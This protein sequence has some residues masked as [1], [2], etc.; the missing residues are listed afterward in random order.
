M[1]SCFRLATVLCASVAA[2]A[3]TMAMAS[4]V[5]AA[6]SIA[7]PGYQVY[8][9]NERSGDVTVINGGD[10]AVAATIAVGKRPR[11]IH[12]SPDGKTV[13]VALS[14][15]PIEAP[16]Q[17]DAHGNP[18]FARKQGKDDDDDDANADKAA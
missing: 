3:A 13:Y 14:G 7:A 4:P 12:V 8:I 18:I 17:I 1:N 10:F 2:A 11:G 6:T 9:T 15:T 5:A 16:P